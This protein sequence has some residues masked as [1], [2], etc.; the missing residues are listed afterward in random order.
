MIRYKE[1]ERY[2]KREMKADRNTE[3]GTEGRV[4]A[5]KHLSQG[6]RYLG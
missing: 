3:T 1:E 6:A 5:Q 2:K 4:Q